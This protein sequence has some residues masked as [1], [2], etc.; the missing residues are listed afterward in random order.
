MSCWMFLM[1]GGLFVVFFVRTIEYDVPDRNNNGNS[2][3]VVLLTTVTDPADARADELASEYQ[4][5]WVRVM[6]HCEIQ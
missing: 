4:Q 1:S 2:E 6:S 5:R 3:L